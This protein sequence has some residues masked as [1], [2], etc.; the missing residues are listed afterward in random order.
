MAVG[1]TS[2]VEPS[3]PYLGLKRRTDPFGRIARWLNV[4]MG[5]EQNGGETGRCFPSSQNSRLA[6]SAIERD[7]FAHNRDN[8]ENTQVAQPVSH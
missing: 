5:V 3:V 8:I 1:S 6:E 2:S 4:M 7:G